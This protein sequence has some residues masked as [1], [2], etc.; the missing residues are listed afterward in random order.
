MDDMGMAA[1]LSGE[2][3]REHKEYLDLLKLRFSILRESEPRLD[4]KDHRQ[5]GKLPIEREIAKEAAGLSAQIA[6]HEL[7][8]DSFSAKRAF[9]PPIAARYGSENQ[10]LYEVLRAAKEEAKNR[11][12][13]LIVGRERRKRGDRIRIA[14]GDLL[15]A[16]LSCEPIFAIDLCEHAYFGD[17]KF[18]KERYLLRAVSYLNLQ[19]CADFS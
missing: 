13:F 18:D 10:F 5:I 7:F 15:S 17:Y 19:K 1:F 8:F 16:M 3:I 14:G 2:S 6:A 12:E 11:S 9:C 4:G